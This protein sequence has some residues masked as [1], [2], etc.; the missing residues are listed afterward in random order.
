MNNVIQHTNKGYIG[1]AQKEQQVQNSYSKG[2]KGQDFVELWCVKQGYF[3]YKKNMKKI[4]LEID[5]IIYKYIE[6]KN[7]LLIR[8]LEVKTRNMRS[9]LYC[10][11]FDQFSINKKWIKVKLCMY[12]IV[13]SIK[14][15]CGFDNSKHCVCYDLAIVSYCSEKSTDREV[16]SMYQYVKNVNLLI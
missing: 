15:D 9:L 8:I 7:I 4:G 12:D 10:S 13:S 1:K 11:D 16:Y 5:L 6:N 3:I 14:K 2:L